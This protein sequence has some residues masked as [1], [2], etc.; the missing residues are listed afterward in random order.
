MDPALLKEKEAFKRRALE[1]AT[2][3]SHVQHKK[4]TQKRTYAQSK[5][6]KSSKPRPVGRIQRPQPQPTTKCE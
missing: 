3:S 1:A 2:S 6:K 5:A 4:D